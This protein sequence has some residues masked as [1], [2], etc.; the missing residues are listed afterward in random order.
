MLLDLRKETAMNRP[1]CVYN[2]SQRALIL[3]LAYLGVTFV[4]ELFRDND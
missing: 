4:R 3:G 2:V 1:D